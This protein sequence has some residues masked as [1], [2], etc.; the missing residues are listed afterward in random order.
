[1]LF[2]YGNAIVRQRNSTNSSTITG[3]S[4]GEVSQANYR[5]YLRNRPYREYQNITQRTD[6]NVMA[7]EKMV[8]TRSVSFPRIYRNTTT[9]APRFFKIVYPAAIT[10]TIIWNPPRWPFTPEQIQGFRLPLVS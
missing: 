9:I 5:A 7:D 10:R 6:Y 8:E 2:T 1:M 3:D 4:T